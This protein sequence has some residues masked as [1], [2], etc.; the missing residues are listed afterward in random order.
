[1]K[2]GTKVGLGPNDIVL[3]GDPAPPPKKRKGG[4]APNFRPLSVVAKR[5]DGLRY[6]MVWGRPRPRRVCFRWGPPSPKI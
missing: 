2:L 4:P 5:L 6:H 3:D 1:M